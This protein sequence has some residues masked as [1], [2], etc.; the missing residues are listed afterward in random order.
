MNDFWE[1]KLISANAEGNASSDAIA[2]TV[3]VRHMVGV[4]SA[5]APGREV[6]GLA[7]WY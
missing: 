2:T 6:F 3:V 1:V 7:C 4:L 5:Q